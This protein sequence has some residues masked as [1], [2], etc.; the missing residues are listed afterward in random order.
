MHTKRFVVIAAAAVA[1]TLTI[2]ACSGSSENDHDMASMTTSTAAPSPSAPAGGDA[3]GQAHNDADVTFAQGMIPHHQ[4]A[5]E[6]SDML[7][8]KQG[9]DQRVV[10]LADVIKAAQGPE[11]QKMQGWLTDWGVQTTTSPP[12]GM[13]NMPNTP[14]HDMGD[15][16]GSGMMS[17]QDMAAL[18][19]AQGVEASRLFLTQMTQ[20][21]K[22][23]ITM[24]QTEVK[25]GQFP[26]AV[27]MARSI[28]SSQQQEIDEMQQM[29]SSL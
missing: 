3:Q 2:A 12:T 7:L 28:I 27:E 23:A 17:E 24:A 19:N 18:Q 4:Q 22:G 1:A 9:I 11:I 20:H 13:P 29:L 10:S 16:G 8:A 15:M 26:P 5:I 6:M 25:S 21:H 14:G